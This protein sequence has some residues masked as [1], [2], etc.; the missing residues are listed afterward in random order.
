VAGEVDVAPAQRDELAASQA[1]VRGDAN[2]LGILAILGGACELRIARTDVD[3]ML[4][5]TR[6]R[7]YRT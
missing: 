5:R 2:D 4:A 3:W 6:E 7:V 1:G